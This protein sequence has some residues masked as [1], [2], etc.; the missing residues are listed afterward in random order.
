MK[1]ALGQLDFIAEGGV[2]AVYRTK[3]RMPAHP[4]T[5]LA[6]KEF[7][8]SSLTPEQLKRAVAEFNQ[9]VRFRQSLSNADRSDLDSRTVWPLEMVTDAGRTVGGLMPLIPQEFFVSLHPPHLNGQERHKPRELAFLPSPQDRSFSAG[10]SQS[11]LNEFSDIVIRAV[12]LAQLVYSVALL[13]KHGIVYGDISLKNAVFA[14][15]QPRVMLLDCDAVAP[16]TDP[17]RKQLNSPY[18]LPPECEAPGSS[19][20]ARG[21]EYRQDQATDVYKLALCVVRG[22]SQ[23]KGATQCKKTDHLV[24]VLPSKTLQTI[25]AALSLDPA[26]RP[27]AKEL[28]EAL[29][30]FVNSMSQSPV[31]NDF[32]PVST[33]VPRN[34]DVLFVW[35]VENATVA[36]LHG[37][38]GFST[39][40]DPNWG[41]YTVSVPKS[42]VYTLEIMK[43]EASARQP[44]DFIQVFDMPDFDIAS[45]TTLSKLVPAIPALQ[46]VEI[47]SVLESLPARPAIEIGADFIPKIPAPSADPI[48]RQL[49]ALAGTVSSVDLVNQAIQTYAPPVLTHAAGIEQITGKLAVGERLVRNVLDSAQADLKATLEEAIAGSLADA[50]RR[51]ND[52]V[53][54]KRN[55]VMP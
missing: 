46:P 32:H 2:G 52:A 21:A 23:G 40:V 24:G 35:D 13:H 27:K 1:G 43:R 36:F 5:A 53:T 42:G 37:P 48:L 17:S 11:Q 16:L 28:F 19:P 55:S 7:K 9:A 39:P 26:A 4:H 6:Y 29:S 51:V 10:F 34:E 50:V 22:L 8:A 30:S 3:Y 33:V 44:S 20:V 47:A 38:N 14:L 18:F 25:N 54:N 15:N 12:L 49:A 41:Q 45:S 31:I